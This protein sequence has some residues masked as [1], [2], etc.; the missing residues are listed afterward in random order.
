MSTQLSSMST[1]LSSVTKHIGRPPI[2]KVAMTGAERQARYIAK[3][4]KARV[5][6]HLLMQGARQAGSLKAM[7]STKRRDARLRRCRLSRH[8]TAPFG[9]VHAVTA[10]S[11]RCSRSAAIASSPPT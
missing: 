5:R 11:L 2:G 3:L 8:L 6:S 7:T 1:Q 10:P 4:K 9:S